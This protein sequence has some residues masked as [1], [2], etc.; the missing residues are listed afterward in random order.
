MEEEP[1]SDIEC[2]P[3]PCAKCPYRKDA[4]LELWSPEEF[5]GVLEQDKAVLGN[6]FACHKHG[7]KK[8]SG[9]PMPLCAGY[10]LDQI[11]RDIPS[12]ALRLLLVRSGNPQR[13]LDRLKAVSANGLA[14]YETIEEMCSANGVT[15]TTSVF[16]GSAFHLEVQA[17]AREIAREIRKKDHDAPSAVAFVDRLGIA[18]KATLAREAPELLHELLALRASSACQPSTDEEMSRWVARAVMVMKDRL[19]CRYADAF[20][21]VDAEEWDSVWTSAIASKDVHAAIELVAS[22]SEM[23]EEY[24][25]SSW[26]TGLETMLAE[27]AANVDSLVEHRFCQVERS[28]MNKLLA[29]SAKCGGWWEWTEEQK[30]STFVPGWV[31][32]GARP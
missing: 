6:V 14:M 18:D 23:S 11:K 10:V 32:P 8:R 26:H 2:E 15:M 22:M 29:L 3:K 1:V 27:R 25:C 24:D 5:K 9:E 13:S 4:P 31:P 28:E 12:N 19:C 21:I 7:K 17:A 20:S 16:Q 30:Q